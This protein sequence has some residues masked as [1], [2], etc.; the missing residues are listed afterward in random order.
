M[1]YVFICEDIED[2]LELR[3]KHRPEHRARLEALINEGRLLVAGP[4]PAIDSEDPG[5]AGYSGSVIV[6]EFDSLE[7]ARQWADEEPY[8]KVG[9]YRDVVVKPFHRTMP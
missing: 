7:Q 2:S 1:Y 8:L 6:A 4:T 9:V 5:P 3:I